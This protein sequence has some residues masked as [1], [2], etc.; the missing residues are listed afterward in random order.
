MLSRLLRLLSLNTNAKCRFGGCKQPVY[1]W[2]SFQCGGDGLFLAFFL[3]FSLSIV[4]AHSCCCSFHESNGGP[5]FTLIE[6][7]RIFSWISSVK[8]P[9][10]LQC[11]RHSAWL[12]PSC[13]NLQS[14]LELTL[15][16]T[17]SEVEIVMYVS[18]MFDGLA[19]RECW[20]F[21]GNRDICSP[22]LIELYDVKCCLIVF[23]PL[24]T[25]RTF[26]RTWNQYL[27]V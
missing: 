25:F 8:L 20:C 5:R 7:K 9:D 10:D 12:F 18:G 4:P 26:V 27:R 16:D 6:L 11:A 14:G 22:E 17:I 21:Y 23:G 13:H 2:Y 3:A 1:A 24:L 15:S 19:G